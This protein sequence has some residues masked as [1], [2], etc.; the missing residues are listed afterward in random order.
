METKTISV[1]RKKRFPRMSEKTMTVLFSGAVIAGTVALSLPT[2]GA[3][4]ENI[5]Q[6]IGAITILVKWIGIL[7]GVVYGIFGFLHY[8]AANAEGDGPGKNKAQNQIAAALMLVAIGVIVGMVSW[9]NLVS[10][11]G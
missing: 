9:N 10:N 6:I 11:I 8:A 1:K 4:D 5:G 3:A 7:L 2:A